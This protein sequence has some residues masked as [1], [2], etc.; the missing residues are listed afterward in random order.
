MAVESN[1]RA[2]RYTGTGACG[3]GR[4]RISQIVG[5]SSGGG[6]GRLTITNGLG[7][8]TLLDVDLPQGNT[9]QFLIPDTGILSDNDP[10]ISAATNVTAVT[11]MFR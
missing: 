1:V 10:Y 7:G 6:S 3:V 8:A 11:I 4:S 2:R 5:T 9:F